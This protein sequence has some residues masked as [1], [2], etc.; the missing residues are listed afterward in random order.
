MEYNLVNLIKASSEF[1]SINKRIASTILKYSDDQ[2]ARATSAQSLDQTIPIDVF[3][4]ESMINSDKFEFP[5]V[6][7][8]VV[9]V[10][11]VT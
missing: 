1:P 3:Q 4:L 9:E 6:E 5:E 10:E 2:D 8:D 11:N 7:M